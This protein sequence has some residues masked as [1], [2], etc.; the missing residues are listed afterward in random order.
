MIQGGDDINKQSVRR[1]LTKGGGLV[2]GYTEE[3]VDIVRRGVGIVRGGGGLSDNK[4][5]ILGV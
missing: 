4:R 3:G 2:G 5:Y 1:G